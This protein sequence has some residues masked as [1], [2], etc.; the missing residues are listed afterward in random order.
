MSVHLVL[1]K[2]SELASR[3]QVNVFHGIERDTQAV[4]RGGYAFVYS[5]VV[6]SMGTRIAIKTVRCGP[7]EQEEDMKR[8]LH[9]IHLWS[10][11]HHEN[12]LPLLGI[13]FEFDHTVSMV[14]AWMEKGNAYEYVQDKSIDPRPLLSDI[15]NGLE[16]LHNHNPPIYHGDLKGNNVLISDDGRALLTD[17]VPL[18]DC[19]LIPANISEHLLSGMVIFVRTMESSITSAKQGLSSAKAVLESQ[20]PTQLQAFTKD[21]QRQLNLSH[22]GLKGAQR[23]FETVLGQCKNINFDLEKQVEEISRAWRFNARKRARA[24]RADATTCLNKVIGLLETT[25]SSIEDMINWWSPI[26]KALIVLKTAG[27][28]AEPL[29]KVGLH[30]GTKIALRTIVRGLKVYEAGMREPMETLRAKWKSQ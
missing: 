7:P 11:L 29:D 23:S 5:G 17:F 16:Y 19:K 25:I 30:D 13:T 2:A 1:A 8:A 21:C 24:E 6:P 28:C 22:G 10:K 14:S 4:R 26:M 3:Y 27:D 18:S 9:E 15:A 12:V 20:D